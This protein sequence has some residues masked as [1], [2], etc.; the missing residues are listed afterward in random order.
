MRTTVYLIITH[1]DAL[2]GIAASILGIYFGAQ[3]AN[4]QASEFVM[5]GVEDVRVEE[6]AVGR[7]LDFIL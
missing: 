4:R 7:P 1:S 3:E 5:A 6:V 2:L